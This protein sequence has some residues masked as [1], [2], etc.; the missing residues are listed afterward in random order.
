MQLLFESFTRLQALTIRIRLRCCSTIS[1][2]YNCTMIFAF[3]MFRI[4]SNQTGWSVVRRTRDSGDNGVW[5]C[6]RA[7]CVR[8]R[9]RVPCPA[10][11]LSALHVAIIDEGLVFTR[12]MPG[13]PKSVDFLSKVM[14]VPPLVSKTGAGTSLDVFPAFF[15]GLHN[16]WTVYKRLRAQTQIQ[17]HNE[18]KLSENYCALKSE[19]CLKYTW[20]CNGWWSWFRIFSI[21]CCVA[22]VTTACS[23]FVL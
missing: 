23:E 5:L 16:I 10:L 4:C 20:P 14:L 9:L 13:I 22:V 1:W 15:F 11:T 7:E 17:T 12:S 21:L 19:S 18:Q 6:T 2:S 3:G 8:L